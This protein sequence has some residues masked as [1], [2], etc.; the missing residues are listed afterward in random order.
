[1][2]SARPRLVMADG[3]DAPLPDPAVVAQ[4]AGLLEPEVVLG[5]VLR[6]PA[7]LRTTSLPVTTL[8]VGPGTRA[9]VGSGRVRPV[10]ARLSAFPGLLAGRLRPTV[11]VVGAHADG[12]RWRLAHSPGWALAA[13]RAAGGLVIER[14]PGPAPAGAPTIE[15]RVVGVIDREDP[16][17]PLPA[18]EPRPEHALIGEL[19]AGLIPRG[20][21]IQWGPGV[22]GAAVVG[23]I[24][25]PVHVRSGLVT[26]ELVELAGRGGLVGEA[27]AAYAWGGRELWDMTAGESPRVRLAGV[28]RTH[29]LSAVSAIK[30][31]VAINTALEVGLDGA[32][33]VETVGGRVVAGPG[34]HP[35]FAAAASRSPGGLSIVALPSR[36][37]GRSAIVV[38]PEVVS[39]PRTDVDVVVTEYGVADLRH[40]SD[41]ERAQRMVTIAA[42]EHRDALLEA[43]STRWGTPV[44]TPDRPEWGGDNQGQAS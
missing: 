29:D 30:R 2:T 3:P 26:D 41:R 13:A 16:P 6:D 10:A 34:G 27:V 8:L 42:P 44:A 40:L 38:R 17:D 9:A 37:G 21:T 14:W 43:A 28:E 23:A 25:G 5:W 19:A 20:A 12:T 15:G 24:A 18:N 1:M 33:N 4:L 31:F 11:L 35:D 39:T 32:V 22:T 36:S 7:W